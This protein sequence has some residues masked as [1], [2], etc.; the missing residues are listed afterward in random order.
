MFASSSSF[1]DDAVSPEDWEGD[2]GGGFDE[3][4]F[5]E[6][7]A[8]KRPPT[9]AEGEAGLA[10]FLIGRY[11]R[12]K[13]T[14]VD[15]CTISYW[16]AAAGATGFVTELAQAPGSGHFSRHL[17]TVLRLKEHDQKQ[18]I[19]KVPG[20]D[21]HEFERAEFR[22]PAIP[23]HEAIQAEVKNNPALLTE[24]AEKVRANELPPSY[25][26]HPV[27][28]ASGQTALPIHLYVD[29]VPVTR[30]ESLLGFWAQCPLS[31]TRHLICVLR[32]SRLCRCGCS[33]WCSVWPILNFIRWSFAA[34]ATGMFPCTRPDGAP[35]EDSQDTIRAGLGGH[36]LSFVAALTAVKG[37]WA[38]Y[39]HTF[40]LQSWAS[41]SY[42]CPFCVTTK[43]TLPDDRALSPA[44]FPFRLLDHKDYDDACSR[45][46][47]YVLL[48]QDAVALVVSK[49]KYDERKGG[50]RGRALTCDLPTLKL[51]KGDR[52]EPSVCLQDVGSLETA[53]TPL[54]VTFWRGECESRVKHRN[55]LV[56]SSLGI[57]IG[58]LRVDLLHTLFLG[59]LKEFCIDAVWELMLADAWGVG[60][61]RSRDELLQYTAE[62]ICVELFAFYDKWR[63]R[64]P[65]E[66]LSLMQTFTLAMVGTP[67]KRCL[68][69]KAAETKGFFFYLC[70]ALS[71]RKNRL[72]RGDVWVAA[73]AA[74][75]RLLDILRACP[76][77]PTAAVV[78]DLFALLLSVGEK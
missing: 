61:G 51:R 4:S 12:G 62:L 68:R 66:P 18:I 58:T 64:R 16:A 19:L 67:A 13:M 46:E 33:G 57:T 47:I 5:A 3:E 45:C 56:D 44:V 53:P 36:P 74:L 29:G 11:M 55:P 21:K 75:R 34:M 22:V 24:L 35:W 40:A 49:L 59:T 8:L 63:T 1:W 17:R 39:A 41:V 43:A 72:H 28:V 78:Q 65:D 52:L 50:A 76:P 37:D 25:T 70:E 14:A 27:V 48:D 38:E 69:T 15:V 6:Y 9:R 2:E 42:P 10:D 30:Q 60:A 23:L 71:R 31:T 54:T 20:F 7:C 26:D 73:A 77:V 32:K